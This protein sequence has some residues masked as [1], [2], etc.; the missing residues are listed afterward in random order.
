MKSFEQ[1]LV[2][3]SAGWVRD[4]VIDEAQRSAILERHPVLAAGQSRFIA[5]VSTVGGLLFA[6]GVSLVIK[7]NWNALGD[8]TKIGGVIAL[9]VAAYAA[10]WKLKIGDGGF[11]KTGDGCLMIGQLLFLCGIALVSQI[12]HLNSRPATGV[13][14]WWLG[15]VAV[16]WITHAKG[17]QFVSI[18][19]GLV[20]CGL[21]MNA[22]DSLIAI[23]GFEPAG[24]LAMY[25]LVGA[26]LWFSGLALRE[27]RWRDFAGLQEKCGLIVASGALF[28]LGFLRHEANRWQRGL[29]EQ[30][31]TTFFAVGLGLVLLVAASVAAWRVRRAEVKA[32]AP[33][34]VLSLVPAL[35]AV[36]VGPIGDGGWLW[37]ALS[38]LTLFVLSIAVVRVGL[39]TAREGWVNLGIVFIAANIIARY[40]DLFGTLLE[41]GVFFIVTGVIV[42]GLGVY[43]EKKRR[44]LVATLRKEVAS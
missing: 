40:F 2:Q 17:A 43:L 20:W 8:W 28:G 15:I 39:E 5:I 32:L 12:F 26:A 9:L 42:A 37:S 44:A 24:F 18:V 21:E 35:G 38:W 30:E 23:R 25:F 3:A 36:A 11:T 41:G 1:S 4:G 34:L 33:W 6:V 31:P 10:G 7:A 13:L 29:A 22:R 27:S 16:P 14:A 19:A